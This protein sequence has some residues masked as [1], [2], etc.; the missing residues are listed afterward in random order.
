LI[1]EFHALMILTG[2]KMN[3]ICRELLYDSA[4]VWFARHQRLCYGRGRAGQ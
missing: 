3:R 1:S 2:V 4:C